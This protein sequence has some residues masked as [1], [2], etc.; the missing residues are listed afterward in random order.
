MGT[1]IYSNDVEVQTSTLPIHRSP[2]IF[3][4]H[5]LYPCFILISDRFFLCPRSVGPGTLRF[6]VLFSSRFMLVL[7]TALH[8][9]LLGQLDSFTYD[10]D[11]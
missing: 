7:D 6:H 11:R 4:T 3:V 1:L 5:S 2:R 8:F 9:E 10:E